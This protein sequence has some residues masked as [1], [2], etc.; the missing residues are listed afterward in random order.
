RPVVKVVAEAQEAP[1]AGLDEGAL[2][3]CVPL[4]EHV[5][6]QHR[7]E[8]RRRLL[9]EGKRP[10]AAIGTGADDE[11]RVRLL[12]TLDRD[13]VNPPTLADAAAGL[14]G[15]GR[16]RDVANAPGR[17]RLADMDDALGFAERAAGPERDVRDRREREQQAELELD[18]GQRRE[19]EK[20][21]VGRGAQ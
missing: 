19:F 7:R 8:Q 16:P 14:P 21:R 6:L 20:P 5:A 15:E 10:S 18:R 9:E 4:Q 11:R 17:L 12:P 2:A 13:A 3:L 1:L